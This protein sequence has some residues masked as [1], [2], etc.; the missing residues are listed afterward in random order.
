MDSNPAAALQKLFLSRGWTL[1][2]AESCT[3]GLLGKLITDQPGSSGYYRG[4][5]VAYSN[6]SKLR[7]LGVKEETLAAK[8]A[9]SPETAR[10]MARGA[11]QLMESSVGAGITG[12]AG[13]GGK[14]SGKPIGL[15]YI[16]L[17]GPDGER[18]KRYIFSGSRADIRTMAAQ[19]ALAMLAAAVESSQH[20][21]AGSRDGDQG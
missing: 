8:G 1:A 12:V 9:V 7:I 20:V 10:E 14:S 6:R 3:G 17:A 21:G 11:R 16:A 18:V 13:P 2:T 5:V 15:V 4:G 19:S